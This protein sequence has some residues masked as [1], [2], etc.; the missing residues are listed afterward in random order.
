MI[1]HRNLT[2]SLCGLRE[3]LDRVAPFLARFTDTRL[4]HILV[5]NKNA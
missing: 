3:L 4:V 2:I 5:L 1:Y